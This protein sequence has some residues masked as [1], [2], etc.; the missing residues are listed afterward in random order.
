VSDDL[1]F[2]DLMSIG[3]VLCQPRFIIV[4]FFPTLILIFLVLAKR[5]A[6]KSIFNVTYLVLSGL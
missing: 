4:F 5:L 3:L 1:Y 6:G 2:V